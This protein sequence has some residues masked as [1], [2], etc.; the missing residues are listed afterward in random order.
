MGPLN[1]AADSAGRYLDWGV[2]QISVT[3]LVII[4]AMVALFIV[5]LLAPFPGH[6]HD[7]FEEK[8]S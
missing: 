4:A 1:V 2:V 5:A 8:D 3:N 7:E 6:R